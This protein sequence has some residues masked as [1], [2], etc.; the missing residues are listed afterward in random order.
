MGC[1]TSKPRT[2]DAICSFVIVEDDLYD[3]DYDTISDEHHGGE[4]GYDSDRGIFNERTFIEQQLQFFRSSSAILADRQEE[5]ELLVSFLPPTV[6]WTTHTH[7]ISYMH[8][9]HPQSAVTSP[10]TRVFSASTDGWSLATLYGKVS[11]M[12]PLVILVQTVAESGHA[13][14]GV[15]VSECISPPHPL[16]VR[17][18]GTTFVFRSI[19]PTEL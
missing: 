17:G 18:D 8:A 3:N 4:E 6:G 15:Y 2:P 19:T 16:E 12:K 13:I 1:S 11:R 5:L 7:T 10:L 14:L 9:N